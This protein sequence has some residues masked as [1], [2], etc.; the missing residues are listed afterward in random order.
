M[1]QTPG[2]DSIDIGRSGLFQYDLSTG[3]LLAKIVLPRGDARH[4]LNDFCLS[5]EGDLYVTDNQSGEIFR[6]PAGSDSLEAFV[7]PGL[8]VSPQGIC[9]TADE[10]LLF[11]A[12]YPTGV[13]GLDRETGEWFRLEPD[14]NTTL[15]GIDGLTCYD[16]DLIAIQNGVQ[17][18]RVLRIELEP[19]GRAIEHVTLIEANHPTFGEPTLGTIQ[20]GWFYYIA[21]SQWGQLGENGEIKDPAS[22]EEPVIL[23]TR[24]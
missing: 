4:I 17:P 14:E 24:L 16:G 2:I 5:R 22:L 7:E 15:Y 9:L 18:N 20:D 13:H 23:K 19:G 10:R 1:S 8:F 3:A 12:D 11:V 21:N 6:L